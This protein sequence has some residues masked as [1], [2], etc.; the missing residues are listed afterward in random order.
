MLFTCELSASSSIKYRFIPCFSYSSEY[1]TQHNH[2]G[3][4]ALNQDLDLFNMMDYIHLTERQQ[5][6]KRGETQQHIFSRMHNQVVK[7]EV[8]REVK[9]EII[10]EAKQEVIQEV[11]QENPGG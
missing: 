3:I 8:I 10:C 9:Q 2:N 5:S 6:S 11:K 1:K 7:Q 4:I